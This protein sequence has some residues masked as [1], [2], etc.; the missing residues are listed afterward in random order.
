MS[1]KVTSWRLHRRT[2]WSL[3]DLAEEVNPALRGWLNVS[4]RRSRRV[5]GRAGCQ[6]MPAGPPMLVD[7]GRDGGSGDARGFARGIGSGGVG[8]TGPGGAVVGVERPGQE[9]V[10][11]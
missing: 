10:Q 4:I 11:G 1:R 2:T 6:G 7:G 3:D 8:V 9:S 5:D